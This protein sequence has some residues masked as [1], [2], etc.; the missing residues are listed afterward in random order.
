VV[1][2]LEAG[3][4]SEES[5]AATASARAHRRALVLDYIHV[6]EAVMKFILVVLATFAFL[7]ACGGGSTANDVMDIRDCGDAVDEESSRARAG[8]ALASV[9]AR[10]DGIPAR[11]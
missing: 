3:G 6:V 11:E 1:V 2:V 5:Q 8:P 10:T 9:E 7:P 4:E